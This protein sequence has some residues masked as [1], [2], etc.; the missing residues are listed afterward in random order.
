MNSYSNRKLIKK[1][2]NG[3]SGYTCLIEGNIVKKVYTNN[4]QRRMFK[5]IRALKLLENY[6]HFP[7]ILHIDSNTIYMT[8]VGI[9]IKNIITLPIDYQQQL[10]EIIEE[11]KECDI[12][13]QDITL[14][15]IMVLNNIL[16]LIDFEKSMTLDELTMAKK[17][18]L[19]TYNV[20]RYTDVSYIQYLVDKL[21][22][23]QKSKTTIYK[24]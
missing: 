9:S 10:A 3:I 20:L 18:K 12:F 13:H 19:P 5:E 14:D 11:L 1:F 4:I 2:T 21:A 16:Y 8:Y 22:Q 6:N 23:K 24:I 17:F 7:K 15:H